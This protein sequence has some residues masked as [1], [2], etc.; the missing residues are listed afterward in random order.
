MSLVYLTP[1]VVW[2]TFFS[3]VVLAVVDLVLMIRNHWTCS[4]YLALHYTVT[5]VIYSFPDIIDT[6]PG[7][8]HQVF[9]YI[10]ERSAVAMTATLHVSFL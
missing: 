4:K 10:L 6:Y 7:L 2:S 3:I 8:R 9:Y 5:S 1:C